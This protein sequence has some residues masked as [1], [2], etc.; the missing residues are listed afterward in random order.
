MKKYLI[1]AVMIVFTL[2]GG[3]TAIQY[4]QT[5]LVLQTS[6]IYPTQRLVSPF[7]L[8]D[9]HGQAF[10]HEQL[11]GKWSLVFVGYTSCPDVCPTTMAKL[12]AVYQALPDNRDLQII[13]LSVDPQRDTQQK[14]LDY[15]NFFN[16][17]FIA[18]TGEHQQL[19]PLTRELGFVYA[20]VGEGDNYQ[21][22][23]SASMTLISPEGKRFATIKPKALKMAQIPQ[24]STNELINDLQAIR[25]SKRL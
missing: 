15:M 16:P 13:F 17:E 8:H 22:D 19:L 25:T 3:I 12:A 11:Q 24:I 6:Y 1:F 23:H 21:V 18:V 7:E 20:M 10:T 9:Q 2:L 5:P 4:S 14:L